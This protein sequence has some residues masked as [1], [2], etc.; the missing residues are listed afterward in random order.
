MSLAQHNPKTPQ[1][2]GTP[3]KLHLLGDPGDARWATEIKDKDET[4]GGLKVA[5]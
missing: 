2:Q 3:H 1:G 4:L 5:T